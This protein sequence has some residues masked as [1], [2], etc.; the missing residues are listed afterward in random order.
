MSNLS[1]VKDRLLMKD[2]RWTLR[3]IQWRKII[4]P[5]IGIFPMR[6]CRRNSCRAF[7]ILQMKDQDF[8]GL[9]FLP[10][11]MMFIFPHPKLGDLIFA[12]VILSG[13]RRGSRR[14]TSV[15]GDF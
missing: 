7:W 8:F 9:V 3:I 6:I 13:A 14:I 15:I 2:L 4:T 11:R 10:Q 12:S 5:T 1:W